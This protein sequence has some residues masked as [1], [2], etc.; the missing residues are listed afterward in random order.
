MHQRS[1]IKFYTCIL[2]PWPTQRSRYLLYL[3]TYEERV[4]TFLWPCFSA[5]QTFLKFAMLLIRREMFT[6]NLWRRLC[7]WWTRMWHKPA[8][9]R[10]DSHEQTWWILKLRRPNKDCDVVKAATFFPYWAVVHA[11]LTITWR[12]EGQLL[13]LWWST[14]PRDGA[15]ARDQKGTLDIGYDYCKKYFSLKKL[16]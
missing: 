16:L 10:K 4:D 13:D 15:L 14:E 5:D 7:P 8:R 9:R 12:E 11:A 3:N 1:A 2:F 6:V